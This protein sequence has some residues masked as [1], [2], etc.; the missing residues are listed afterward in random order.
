M[1]SVIAILLGGLR[2]QRR[3][4][5]RNAAQMGS[6]T[7][8]K[9]KTKRKILL[10]S[11]R[12][13]RRRLLNYNE[14]VGVNRTMIVVVCNVAKMKRVQL[15]LKLVTTF[16]KKEREEKRE[17]VIY[18]RRVLIGALIIATHTLS[19]TGIRCPI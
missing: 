11:R 14:R 9:I 8:L 13:L 5:D 7:L 10:Y 4:N 15:H 6:R 16:L 12:D 17:K 18:V 19:T 3:V 2:A 1:R